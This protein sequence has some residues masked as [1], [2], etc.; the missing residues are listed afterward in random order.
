ML[1]RYLLGCGIIGLI[2][3]AIGVLILFQMSRDLSPTFMVVKNDSDQPFFADLDMSGTTKEDAAGSKVV[4]PA[5]FYGDHGVKIIFSDGKVLWL[6]YFLTDAAWAGNVDITVFHSSGSSSAHVKCL[7]HR[8][9][10]LLRRYLI[11]FDQEVRLSSFS[12]EAPVRL[13]SP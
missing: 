1:K 13:A 12:A 9:P 3:L 10:A 8:R 2:V 5:I 11:D 4:S 7:T 6:G